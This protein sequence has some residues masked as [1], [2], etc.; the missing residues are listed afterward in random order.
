MTILDER[1]RYEQDIAH[2]KN[3]LDQL[4]AIP[5]ERV[6]ADELHELLCHKCRAS[7][8]KCYIG[9]HGWQNDRYIGAPHQRYIE[10]VGVLARMLGDE[11]S[12]SELI[13]TL[14]ALQK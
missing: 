12:L 1:K 14:A 7:G 2:A 9:Q 5:T 10:A 13:S 4:L 3:R 8:A 11:E 6:L